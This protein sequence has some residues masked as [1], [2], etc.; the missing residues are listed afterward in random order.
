MTQWK[1]LHRV[2]CVG[3]RPTCSFQHTHISLCDC[4]SDSC[5]F[6]VTMYDPNHMLS[7]FL[8]PTPFFC[9]CFQSHGL[10]SKRDK[11]GRNRSLCLTGGRV[12]H[13]WLHRQAADQTKPNQT[14]RKFVLTF[15]LR[16]DS[17]DGASS[18]IP[19]FS[20]PKLIPK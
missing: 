16:F 4:V 15:W 18:E 9:F 19:R 10:K 6:N 8:H 20:I 14:N 12:E 1:I 7:Q 3:G 13:M 11:R 5:A 17:C 2:S